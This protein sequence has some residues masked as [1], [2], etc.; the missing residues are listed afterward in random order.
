MKKAVC[1]LLVLL[2]LPV[3]VLATTWTDPE[4]PDWPL[5]VFEGDFPIS[6]RMPET[7]AQYQIML[8]V[9]LKT[10]RCIAF[11]H[12]QLAALIR[13]VKIQPDLAL[14]YLVAKID[15]HHIGPLAIA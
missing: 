2:L 12:V 9:H 1:L 7:G 8:A 5:T 10:N 6:D 4:W 14:P 13:T 15:R 3:S 11:Q